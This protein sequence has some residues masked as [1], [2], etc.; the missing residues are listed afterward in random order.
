MPS[1]PALASG[2]VC[3]YPVRRSVNQRSTVHQFCDL[4]EQRYSKGL[5]LTDFVLEYNNLTT[6]D[7]ETL[8]AFYNSTS[9]TYATNWSWTFDG[10]HY[11][12]CQFTGRFQAQLVGTGTWKV[13]LTFRT[14]GTSGFPVPLTITTAELTVWSAFP[15]GI[16]FSEIDY[17][18][19][20]GTGW[21]GFFSGISAGHYALRSDSVSL[22]SL[23][24]A[25]LGSQLQVVG[26]VNGTIFETGV[27]DLRIYDCYLDVTYS[28]STTARLR[29]TRTA[30]TTGTDGS[31]AT[32]PNLAIDTDT[33]P[34]TTYASI[35]R[36]HTSGFAIAGTLTLSRFSH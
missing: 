35:S 1:L 36:F 25:Q 13:T 8:R 7:K 22:S 6:V 16:G 30:V 15:S 26:Y 10:V 28:D 11:P 14:T 21:T 5:P 27:A 12:H 2:N 9:G 18:T 3:K 32:N 31:T 34:P 17:S 23:T 19:N 33:I 4:S 20:G 29:P 24:P